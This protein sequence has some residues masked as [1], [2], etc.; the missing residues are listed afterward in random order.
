MFIP[1]VLEEIAAKDEQ[2]QQQDK[3]TEKR[4]TAQEPAILV[5]D[6]DSDLRALTQRALS[7]LGLPVLQAEDGYDAM[8][9]LTQNPLIA[10]VVLDLMMPGQT[11]DKTFQEIRKT[12]PVL[13][14]IVCTG[15]ELTEA[16]KMFDGNQPDL[17]ITKPYK[18][19]HLIKSASTFLADL[20][21]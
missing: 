18:P 11:G 10:L 16:E 1:P 20:G 17:I 12:F 8:H 6:D 5:V 21:F 3:S 15:Q 14:V 7:P 19:S 9:Q 4:E 2:N 13:P